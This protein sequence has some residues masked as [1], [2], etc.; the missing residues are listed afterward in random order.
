M[1]EWWVRFLSLHDDIE[2]NG[3]ENN[4]RGCTQSWKQ[5]FSHS[6]TFKPFPIKKIRV[7]N[8]SISPFFAHDARPLPSDG[9]H[10]HNLLLVALLQFLL[11][12]LVISSLSENVSNLDCNSFTF[13][14]KQLP[15]CSFNGS[16]WTTVGSAKL[17]CVGYWKS[18]TDDFGMFLV[19]RKPTGSEDGEGWQNNR[20]SEDKGENL[21]YSVNLVD[22]QKFRVASRHFGCR[23]LV[24]FLRSLHTTATTTFVLISGY[25]IEFRLERDR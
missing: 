11:N 10:H 13:L 1:K 17:R 15:K 6:L 4:K 8:N 22:N 18:L 21:Q 19:C 24:S 3:F 12:R 25:N 16:S 5:L 7:E 2:C 20:E 23:L 9:V 14:W